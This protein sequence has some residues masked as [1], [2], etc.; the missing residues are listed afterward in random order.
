M[1]CGRCL[2]VQPYHE[3]TLSVWELVLGSNRPNT[4]NSWETRPRHR[5]RLGSTT[6]LVTTG[7]TLA[8]TYRYDPWGQ[9]IGTNG[10]TYNPFQFTGVYQ[11]SATNLYRMT[12][13]LRWLLSTM[14]T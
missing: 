5:D 8:N 2:G 9:S 12:Q 13:R 1:M 10:T 6:A 3:Y 14:G 7:Q 4:A 11:D